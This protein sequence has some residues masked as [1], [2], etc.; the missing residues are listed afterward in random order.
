MTDERIWVFAEWIGTQ[1]TPK[2]PDGSQ[3]MLGYHSRLYNLTDEAIRVCPRNSEWIIVT[4]GD[5]L[6][7]SNLFEKVVATKNA[8]LIA[9]DYYTRYQRATGIPCERFQ[10]EEG[11]PP[12]KVNHLQWCKTDLGANIMKIRKL[13]LNSWQ[14]GV[15]DDSGRFTGQDGIMAQKLVEAGWRVAHFTDTCLFD[16]SPSPQRCAR[17]GNVWDDSKANTHEVVGG[18]CIVPEA[19]EEY[20][21][22]NNDTLE[23][24]E[25]QV[26][27]DDNLKYYANGDNQNTLLKC[28][29]KKGDEHKEDLMRFYGPQCADDFDKVA[30]EGVDWQVTDKGYQPKITTYRNK[31]PDPPARNSSKKAS[32]RKRYH[33]S[34]NVGQPIWSKSDN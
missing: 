20:L 3:W 12:C 34:H 28:I 22:K 33:G 5:N 1:Y 23:M 26:S 8:D 18:R 25:I 31:Y 13:V 14:F 24:I 15:L 17:N 11:K 19:A 32:Y 2:Q 10:K 27:H 4:N 6:Y 29:R 21:Q 30:F 16:H 9:L 7:A